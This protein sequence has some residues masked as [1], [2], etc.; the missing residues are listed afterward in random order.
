MSDLTLFTFIGETVTNATNAF[1]VPAANDLMFKL[2]MV[3][4]A[5]VTLYITLTGY[6]IATGS[7][8]SPFW[9]FLKQCAKVFVIAYFALSADGYHAQV[10]GT[11]NGIETGLSDVLKISSPGAPPSTIYQTLDEVV[12]KG[13]Q[14]ASIAMQKASDAGWDFGAAASWF[15]TGIFVSI[16][17][18]IFAIVGGVNIIVAKFSLAVMFALGPLFIACAMFPMTAQFFD[19]WISQ[20]MNYIFTVVIMA[21]IMSFGVVAFNGFISGIDL[22]GEGVQNPYIAGLQVFGLTLIL[23]WIAMQAGGMASGLAGGVSTSALSLRQIASGATSPARAVG[24][25]HNVVNPTSTRLDPRTGQQTTARRAEHLA[26]GRSVWARNPAYRDGIKE[27]LASA[28]AKQP[29]GDVKGK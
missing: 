13:S 10:V 23:S 18:L 6:A 14:L 5:G 3:V 11:L 20:V 27:R 25:A 26:M 9:T 12:D 21:L 24:A 16:G 22:S 19:R 15:I 8:E 2:Q 4:L 7:V 28:W 17:T 29:G 1:M